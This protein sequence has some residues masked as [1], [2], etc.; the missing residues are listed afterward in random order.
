M[1]SPKDGKK[2]HLYLFW[3]ML[4]MVLSFFY[5]LNFDGKI[6]TV[7]EG[8]IDR[9][10]LTTGYRMHAEQAYISLPN[11]GIVKVYFNECNEGQDVLVY[12]RRGAF[13]FNTVYTADSR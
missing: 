2:L 9:C 4:I 5:Q 11:E 10:I 3:G 1:E 13:Y 6:L 8:K 12:K 7:S